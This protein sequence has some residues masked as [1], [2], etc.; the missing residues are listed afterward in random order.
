MLSQNSLNYEEKLQ[1]GVMSRVDWIVTLREIFYAVADQRTD[2]KASIK[3]E[4]LMIQL[5][6]Q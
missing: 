1:D 2:K 6:R 5:I 3:A 4:D